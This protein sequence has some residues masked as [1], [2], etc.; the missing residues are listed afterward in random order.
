MIG[1][2]LDAFFRDFGIMFMV[3]MVTE[4]YGCWWGGEPNRR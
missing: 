3:M 2:Y 1:G 4:F